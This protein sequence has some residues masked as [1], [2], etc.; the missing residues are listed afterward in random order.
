MNKFVLS[1]S[2]KA[3]MAWERKV[4]DLLIE[5]MEISN[6]DAQNF[7]DAR[8]EFVGQEWKRR[9]GAEETAVL[10]QEV[11]AEGATKRMVEN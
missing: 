4:M 3:F 1:P 11:G 7:I 9:S 6:G 5:A 10:I 8:P 2:H